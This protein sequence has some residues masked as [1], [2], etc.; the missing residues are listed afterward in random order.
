MLNKLKWVLG[1]AL[2]FVLILT[3]NLI[4]RR[5]FRQVKESI[6]TI[7]DDHLVT[8]DLVLELS[9]HV[10]EKAIAVALCDSAFF[11]SQNKAANK[12]IDELIYDLEKADLTPKADKALNRF[13]EDFE[14]LK[15]DEKDLPQDKDALAIQLRDFEVARDLR[16]LGQDLDQLAEIQMLEGRREMFVGKQAV[17]AV[18]LLTKMEIYL[19]IGM[20]LLVQFMILYSPKRRKEEE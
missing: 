4:D 5:N 9:S 7:Y 13:K 20:A 19:L 17:D 16:D 6:I 1:V 15:K 8:K 10:H 11:A 3:T 14:T 12:R 2:V 18:E